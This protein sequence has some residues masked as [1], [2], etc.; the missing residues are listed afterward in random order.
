[1]DFSN[2]PSIY[3]HS[4]ILRNTGLKYSNYYSLLSSHVRFALT[5]D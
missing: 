1:M 4:R 2:P 3:V 5:V